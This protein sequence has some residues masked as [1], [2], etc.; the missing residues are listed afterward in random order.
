[1]ETKNKPTRKRRRQI[2]KSPLVSDWLKGYKKG[3]RRVYLS[4]FGMFLDWAKRTPEQMVAE[5]KADLKE[6]D[7][8][9]QHRYERLILDCFREKKVESASAAFATVKAVRAFFGYHYMPLRFRR[10]E[11]QEFSK[12]VKPVYVDYIPTR[13]ELK[14]MVEVANVRDRAIV[15]TLASTGISGDVCELTRQQFETKWGKENPICLAPRGGYLY[16]TKTGVKMRP[17]LTHDAAQAIKVCLKTRRDKTPW[18]FVGKEGEKLSSEAVNKI[19]VRLAQRAV[20]PVPP[21]SRVRM[22]CFRKFFNEAANYAD[23]TREWICILYGHEVDG[24]EE[25]YVTA[26][27]DKLREKFKRVEPHLSVSRLTNMAILRGQ[28]QRELDENTKAILT[29]LSRV[30]DKEDLLDAAE[31]IISRQGVK[32]DPE[33]EAEPQANR[34]QRILG[35]VLDQEEKGRLRVPPVK[36]GEEG[37]P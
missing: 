15:L 16:R 1:M 14:A 37:N 33:K 29:I 4:A 12:G 31:Y 27:E 5:R 36:Y 21:G 24:S 30:V 20:I 34:I 19:V 17:F 32:W 25:F 28:N 2:E 11:A 13:E 8:A 7:V 10:L 23:V 35:E 26:T 22:H 6:E 3:S 18:L 9:A